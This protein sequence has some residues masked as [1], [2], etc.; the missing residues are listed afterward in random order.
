MRVFFGLGNVKLC[1]A[2]FRNRARERPMNIKRRKS[3][4]CGESL[5]VFCHCNDK[6]IGERNYGKFRKSRKRERG[7]QFSLGVL[8]KIIKNN[9][10]S[11]SYSALVIF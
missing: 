6:K 10:V 4:L 8:P 7:N 11:R 5:I 1:K 9:G 2:G 3:N